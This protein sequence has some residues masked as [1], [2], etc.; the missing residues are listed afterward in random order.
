MTPTLIAWTPITCPA[1]ARNFHPS[2]LIFTAG[3]CLCL[4]VTHKRTGSETQGRTQGGLTQWQAGWSSCLERPGEWVWGSY[5]LGTPCLQAVCHFQPLKV[6][7]HGLCSHW[8][9]I[10]S[11]SRSPGALVPCQSCTALR[12][13]LGSPPLKGAGAASP[14]CAVTHGPLSTAKPRRHPSQQSSPHFTLNV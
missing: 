6:W 14:A 13:P 1:C 11:V 10:H 9:V 2:S 12:L 3:P 5:H 7:G 4:C 8:Q